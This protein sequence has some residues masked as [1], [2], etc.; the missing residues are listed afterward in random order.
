[1]A[2]LKGVIF[3]LDNVIVP[4]GSLS[5]HKSQLEECGKLA[6][7]LHKRGVEIVILT[8]HDYYITT[9]RA[10]AS[11][12]TQEP[13]KDFFENAWKV[14]IAWHVCGQG[15]TAGKQSHAGFTSI[16]EKRKWKPNNAIFV[17]NSTADMQAA[18]NNKVLL[19][20]AKWYPDKPDTTEYG[21]LMSSPK[22]VAR[23]VDVFCLRE[24]YWYY[25]IKDGPIEVYALAPLGSYFEESKY[26][27]DDFMLNIKNE[28]ASDDE[29][30]AKF[31]S[32]SLYFSGVY[33]DVDY[34]TAYPKHTAN[35]YQHVLIKPMD[36]FG[37]S[38]NKRYIPDLI[39]RHTTATKS[40]FYRESVTHLTQL[41][42]IR[43]R[44][45]PT[46]IVHGKPKQYAK[47]PIEKGKTVLV[48]DDVCT[49]GMSFEAARFYLA[50]IGIRVISVALLKARKH[51]YAA[52]SSVTLESGVFGANK[53]TQ[54][55]A[56]KVYPLHEHIVDTQAISE[57]TTRLKR[58]KNWDWPA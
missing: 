39:E 6:R 38:F 1:M 51:G 58:Y 23:F 27:S 45:L 3:G 43:L 29:Y 37:K 36:T 48:V 17:G 52:L 4:K 55:S 16:L 20:T 14:P 41:E 26:Y 28:L 33:E 24:H 5:P 25:K 11:E 42:T 47:F 40:Q 13:A 9:T 19:L 15:G 18:V 34:I 44:R 7:F 54:H 22:E 53:I 10:G 30:W 12:K 21:F 50:G 32:T 49:K 2:Q 8:N 46:R 57:M 31:L 35:K 56:G